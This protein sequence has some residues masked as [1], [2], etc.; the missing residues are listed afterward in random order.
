MR[1][2]ATLTD[3]V[4]IRHYLKGVGLRADPPTIAPARPPPQLELD[5][6]LAASA[7]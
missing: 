2:I 7:A 4:S 6:L 1:I 3:E 5:P